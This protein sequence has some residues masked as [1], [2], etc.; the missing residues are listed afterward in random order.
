M[1]FFLAYRKNR[2]II[3]LNKNKKNKDSTEKKRENLP[4]KLN[5]LRE[6][7]LIVVVKN[8]RA[9]IKYNC[10]IYVRIG[11]VKVDPR[12]GGVIVLSIVKNRRVMYIYN[13]NES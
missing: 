12:S 13:T 6:G 3:S 7:P 4:P 11:S 2:D 8:F 1:F 9:V 10:I 5:R